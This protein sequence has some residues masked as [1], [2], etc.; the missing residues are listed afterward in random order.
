MAVRTNEELVKDVLQD[1]YDNKKRRNLAVKIGQA[2]RITDRLATRASDAGTPLTTAELK[3][4][5]TYLAAWLYTIGD[6]LPT[7]ESAGGESV[8]YESRSY[9]EAAKAMDAS[10][11]L[12]GILAP[13]RASIGWLG[14][15]PSAQIPFW[16]RS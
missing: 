5:E 10:G 12:A 4:V 7:S 2:S 3:D 16:E 14:K 6:P 1:N 11:L 15:V 8:S 13:K 9:L